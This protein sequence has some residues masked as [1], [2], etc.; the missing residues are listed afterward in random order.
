MDARV[1]EAPRLA[2]RGGRRAP[3]GG[4]VIETVMGAVVI[5]VAAVF[6]FFAYTTS[7]VGAGSGYELT[8]QFS[9]VDGLN[10]GSDVSVAGVKIGAVTAETLDPRT[11]LATVHMTIERQYKLPEDSIAKIASPGLLGSKY[12]EIV[13]GGSD[14]ALPPGGRIK[15]TQAS[16]S[17]EDLIGQM[18]YS[19]AGGAGKAG[20]AA[21]AP[22]AGGLSGGL[23]PGSPS[24]PAAPK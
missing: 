6:L 10:V 19:P 12:I 4:N 18:I 21:P 15:Y 16:V 5:A 13:P 2:R 1:D 22:G 7:H 24:P 20:G 17:L 23:P 11:F 9:S 8:A 14:K 3:T